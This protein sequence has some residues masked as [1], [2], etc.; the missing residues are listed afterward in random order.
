MTPRPNGIVR[1][2]KKGIGKMAD[3]CPKC[4]GEMIAGRVPSPQ[5]WLLG[6]KSDEQKRF[7]F[8]SNIQRASA[9]TACGYVEL[10][11]DPEEL[12][13]KQP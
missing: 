5:K 3:A 12:K 2:Q 4:G 1:N 6:F 7:S 10:Y 9:C 8:E 13:A 11:L